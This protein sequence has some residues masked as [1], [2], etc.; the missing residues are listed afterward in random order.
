MAAAAAA[1][2]SKPW[3][4]EP[5]V[6]AME[7]RSPAAS[8]GAAR[9]GRHAPGPYL[10]SARGP[11]G[12]RA[13]AGGRAAEALAGF[14]EPS[15]ETWERSA[16][17]SSASAAGAGVALVGLPL[18]AAELLAAAAAV[19]AEDASTDGSMVRSAARRCGYGAEPA[20]LHIGG[21]ALAP[22]NA[23]RSA[24]STAQPH[25]RTRTML[26]PTV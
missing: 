10:G 23:W 20:G 8:A 7:R 5:W 22:G 21:T 24:D 25:A 17:G 2:G 1:L 4:A 15:E 3:A 13:D 11:A 26:T 9:P 19:A 6:G 18:P 16:A 14:E 12:L